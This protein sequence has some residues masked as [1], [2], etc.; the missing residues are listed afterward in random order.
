MNLFQTIK[1][2]A[3]RALWGALAFAQAS[4]ALF[5]IVIAGLVLAVVLGA[6]VFFGNCGKSSK[7][8]Q[9]EINKIN[10]ADRAEREKIFREVI[11]KNADTVQTV[12]NRT[13]QTEQNIETRN[14][15]IEARIKAANDAVV[16]ARRNNSNITA[17]ELENLLL[18]K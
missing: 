1:L 17:E 9:D 2:Y 16:E 6:G 5:W 8:N 14:Q 7:I 4:P 3:E 13:L 15:V 12:D 18:N 10:A 11:E